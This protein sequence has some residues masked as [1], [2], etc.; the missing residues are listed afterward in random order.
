MFDEAI[1][2]AN[3]DGYRPE[4]SEFYDFGDAPDAVSKRRSVSDDET[5]DDE[6]KNETPVSAGLFDA[7]GVG[8]GLELVL[9]DARGRTKQFSA[10][11][12]SAGT[13]SRSSAT[14]TWRA[15]A[16]RTSGRVAAAAPA[17]RLAER[18]RNKQT[19]AIATRSMRLALRGL[20]GARGAVHHQG[21]V[22]GQ[23]GASRGRA[24]LGRG[25]RREPLPH[26][27]EQAVFEGR[28]REGRGEPAQQAG[29]QNAG[30]ARAGGAEQAEPGERLRRRVEVGNEEGV[31]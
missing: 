24:P 10:T 25:R 11:A 21:A 19:N 13:T 9:R 8:G 20:E 3:A 28:A 30:C 5:N 12:R 17:A 7:R 16:R 6:T 29:R 4:Y 27:R 2:R 26:R 14:I 31:I 1:A 23:R 22:R 18:E 15:G